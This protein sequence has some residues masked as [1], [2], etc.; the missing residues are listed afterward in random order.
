MIHLLPVVIRAACALVLFA[1]PATAQIGGQVFDG[2][3]GPLL[4]GMVYTTPGFTV[5]GNR[6]LTMEVGAILKIDSGQIIVGGTFN[7]VDN[8]APVGVQAIVTSIHDDSAGGDTNN[9]GG[10]TVPAAGDWHRLLATAS[11]FTTDRLEVRYGGAGNA[12][13][14]N[15]GG[16]GVASFVDST[17]TDCLGAAVTMNNSSMATFDRCTIQ[18]C[19]ESIISIPLASVPGIVDCI[20]ANNQNNFMKVTGLPWSGLRTVGPRNLLGT[21]VLFLPGSTTVPAGATLELE[22]GTI[23]RIGLG[24][25]FDVAGDMRAIGTAAQPIVFTSA[26]DDPAGGDVN[27]NGPSLGMPGDWNSL[28]FLTGSGASVIEHLQMR[29][30]G[31]S[32]E[33]GLRIRD[34]IVMRK[35]RVEECASP[36]ANLRGS[37]ASG[38]W[39]P[40]IVECA[41]NDNAGVA[42]AN[43]AWLALPNFRDNTATGNSAGDV[44]VVSASSI[45]GTVEVLPWNYPGPVLEVDFISI[46]PGESLTVHPGVIMKVGGN[47]G[48]VNGELN[49][50]G[51]GH[52][53]VVVTSIEDDRYGGDTKKDGPPVGLPRAW[54]GFPSNPGAT[55]RVHHAILAYGG[56]SGRP[57]LR[58]LA[59]NYDLYGVRCEHSLGNAFDIDTSGVITQCVAWKCREGFQ[60]ADGITQELHFCTAVGNTNWGFGDRFTTTSAFL[61]CIAWGN[62]STPAKDFQILGNSTASFSCGANVPV[63]VGN[64]LLNPMFVN[65]ANGDLRLQ[66]SSPCINRG[67]AS[68]PAPLPV[69]DIDE[70]SRRSDANLSGNDN[71]D[72]G[73]YERVRWELEVD[74]DLRPGEVMTLGTRGPAG[75]WFMGIGTDFWASHFPPFGYLVINPLLPA[76]FSPLGPFAVDLSGDFTIALG[77]GP[78]PPGLNFNL[79]AFCIGSAA[80]GGGGGLTNVCRLVTH[81]K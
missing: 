69:V 56:S 60:I 14:L 75:I 15:L 70:N 44:F 34:N 43:I 45:Q 18:N 50:N 8:G 2:Q 58:L 33:A 65:E 79:Q 63:G 67:L 81:P 7:V 52:R 36:G 13:C 71:P 62:G 38:T 26:N 37:S 28:S 31:R 76:P 55:M 68:L 4:A 64:T 66:A 73:A 22:P 41:F 59:A 17:I 46:L 32:G 19:A 20:A 29:Y 10:A 3:G 23:V 5:P 61:N 77:A 24:R 72:M 39:Q 35:S 48:F 53:K 40:T 49:I 42:F 47:A 12:P 80:S 57:T 78:L 11:T 25:G 54:F 74:G 6:T 1:L 9:N 51:S 21:S 30:G 27:G 16:A